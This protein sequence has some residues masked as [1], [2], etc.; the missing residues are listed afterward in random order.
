[1][2]KRK[3]HDQLMDVLLLVAGEVSGSEHHKPSGSNQS[4]I[5]VPVGTKP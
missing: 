1:M 4:V 3:G 5:Y 2:A